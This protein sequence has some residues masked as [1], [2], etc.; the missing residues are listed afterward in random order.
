MLNIEVVD[1]EKGGRDDIIFSTEGLI[2]EQV[3][4]SYWLTVG[5]NCQSFQD[6]KSN[7]A[8]LL[9]RW[10]NEILNN[11][12]NSK[13]IYLAIDI[14][15]EYIGCIRVI[16]SG[17]FLN[18]EHGFTRGQHVFYFIKLNTIGDFSAEDKTMLVN[19]N[20]FLIILNSHVNRLKNFS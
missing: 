8:Y 12:D 3:Q 1:N 9:I 7:V 17:D 4:D 15:N 6:V 20:E 10:E 5:T 11:A 19:K 16:I 14:S 2:N 18:L 13:P